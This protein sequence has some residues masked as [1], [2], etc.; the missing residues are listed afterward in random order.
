MA[1]KVLIKRSN[2]LNSDGTVKLPTTA[3]MSYG[4]LAMNYNDGHETL[5]F[6]NSNDEIVTF[7][8]DADVDTLTAPP[9]SSTTIGSN[10]KPYRIGDKIRVA[11]NSSVSFYE[12]I[13]IGESGNRIWIENSS[14][15]NSETITVVITNNGVTDNT[16]DFEFYGSVVKLNYS[17]KSIEIAYSGQEIN[18]TIE[19][20]VEYSIELVP[21]SKTFCSNTKQTFTSIAYNKRVVN[22][23]CHT[24]EFYK[25]LIDHTKS[26]PSQIFSSGVTGSNRAVMEWIKNNTHRYLGKYVSGDDVMYLC[27]LDD[28]NS[29]KFA[30]DGTAAAL[31]GTQGDVF[32]RIPPFSYKSEKVSGTDNNWNVQLTNGNYGNDFKYW[33]GNELIGAWKATVKN[34]KIYSITSDTSATTYM[35]DNQ[36]WDLVHAKYGDNHGKFVTWEQHS[37][38]SF[39]FYFYYLNTDAQSILGCAESSGQTL[40]KFLTMEDSRLRFDSMNFWGLENWYCDLSEMMENL[41]L[42]GSTYSIS[43]YDNLTGAKS[44]ISRNV[45]TY[46]SGLAYISQTFVG[47]YLDALPY[48][49]YASSSTGYCGNFGGYSGYNIQ[50]CGLKNDEPNCF[51]FFRERRANTPSYSH[52]VRLTYVGPIEIISSSDFKKITNFN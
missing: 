42:G 31:D 47:E 7:S 15:S 37:M 52:T 6:R 50:R 48:V 43:T 19:P 51:N 41:Y 39:L 16:N 8:P 9:S 46:V 33:S 29:A 49:E 40:G 27:Q 12:L 28:Y 2:V 14:I 34:N 24:Q 26:E 21:N 45:P 23:Y 10:G 25:V 13:D 35:T 30:D 22:F 11:D 17:D 18:F 44:N 3:N 1:Q 4:E 38:V 36:F 32:V 5:S 20:K